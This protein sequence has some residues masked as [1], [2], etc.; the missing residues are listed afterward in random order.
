MY[1]NSVAAFPLRL[2]TVGKGDFA[3]L[4]IDVEDARLVVLQVELYSESVGQGRGEQ[5]VGKVKRFFPVW[6]VFPVDAAFDGVI[7]FGF[8]GRFY[9]HSFS[10]HGIH[11]G[12]GSVLTG[13]RKEAHCEQAEG[14]DA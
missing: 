2:A 1:L 6:I 14:E 10:E 13:G 8:V 4:R 3:S 12:Q 5:L 11:V 9:Q 7:P